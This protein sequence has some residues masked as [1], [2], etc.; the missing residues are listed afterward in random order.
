M[1]E[2]KAIALAVEYRCTV[3]LDDRIARLKAKSMELKVKGTIGLLRLTYDKGLIDKGKLVQ[4][5][6][7]LKEHGFRASDEI[8]NE[9]L[10]KLK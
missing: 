4:A 8:I 6:K 1:D 10:R 3:I 7:G 5:L 2:S 9:V